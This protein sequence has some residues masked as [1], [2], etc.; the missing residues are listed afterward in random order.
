M[1]SRDPLSWA[2]HDDFAQ[3]IVTKDG[4]A[5]LRLLETADIAL[6]FARALVAKD[7][8]RANAM[9]STALKPSYPP[10]TLAEHLKQMVH[11]SENDSDWPTSVQVVTGLDR[12]DTANS[13]RSHPNDFGWAYVS[14]AGD[15][16]NEAVS[17]TVAE[18][19]D[20]LVIRTI[21]WGRP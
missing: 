18:E 8:D 2:Y 6:T 1:P 12:S 19:Q 13:V 7:Y 17:V 14:I 5:A 9:L 10:E 15:G 4:D 3:V 16:Y 21:E 20:R 11:C